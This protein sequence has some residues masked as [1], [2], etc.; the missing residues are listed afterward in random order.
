MFFGGKLCKRTNCAPSNKK[1]TFF[2]GDKHS[3][4]VLTTYATVSQKR[5]TAVTLVPK[6][7][8]VIV[9]PR[10]APVNINRQICQKVAVENLFFLQRTAEM[11]NNRLII[12]MKYIAK[13]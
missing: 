12:Y 11:S 3:K 6:F 1:K 10:T 9:A 4:N 5:A 8:A 2:V 7:D 13:S